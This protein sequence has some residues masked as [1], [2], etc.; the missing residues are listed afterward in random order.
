MTPTDDAQ[1]LPLVEWSA[2]LVVGALGGGMTAAL[3]S[4]GAGSLS[5]PAVALA[6]AGVVVLGALVLARRTGR[7]TVDLADVAVLVLVAVGAWRGWAPSVPWP[8]YLDPSWYSNTAAQIA[9][10]GRLRFAV[11]AL[12]I[13]EAARAAFVTTFRDERDSGLPFPADERRGFHDVAFAVPDVARAEAVPYH[14]PAFAAWLAAGFRMAGSRGLGWA[15]WIWTVAWLLAAAALARAAFGPPAAP[16]AAGLLA[17]SPAVVYYAATPFAEPAAGALALVGTLGLVR[18]AGGGPRPGWAA[19]AGLAL[20]AAVVVKVDAALPALAGALWWL[21]A[22]ARTGGPREGLAL[23]A[24][25]AGSAL[26]MVWLAT[27][28]SALYVSLNGGGVLAL[29]LGR[30]PLVALLAVLTVI[31]V[32]LVGR[33]LRRQPRSERAA[34]ERRLRRVVAA[35]VALALGAA[36]VAGWLAG[37]DAAPGPVAILAW[38]LTPLGLWAAV[39]GLAWALD[40]GEPRAGP[41]LAQALLAGGLV[42]AAPVVTQTLSSLYTGRRL[43]PLA[44]PIAAVLAGGAVAAWWR[45]RSTAAADRNRRA[46]D[47]AVGGALVLAG[48]ALVAAGEPLRGWREFTGGEVLARRVVRHTGERDVL[49]FPNTLGGADPGRMAA[50]IWAL[51]GRP[52]AV[53]APG[54]DPALIGEAVDAWRA[55]GRKVFYVTDTAHPPEALPPGYRSDLVAEEAIVTPAVAPRPVLPPDSQHVDLQ[56]QVYELAPSEE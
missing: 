55:A 9:R 21:A 22:R 14:P 35:G 39:A 18:L 38:L 46:W 16:V 19:L 53:L 30:W 43:V 37:P 10:T 26:V 1:R 33:W 23:A 31:G 54:R 29:V 34:A 40:A 28:V 20:G 11:E 50:S 8:V 3:L 48:V 42:L 51:T 5:L 52:T 41:V 56:L 47:L 4:A 7:P 12:D 36:L 13:P 24:G 49:V 15:A 44:L 45:W 32:V 17:L 6:A 25:A 2:L 27:G